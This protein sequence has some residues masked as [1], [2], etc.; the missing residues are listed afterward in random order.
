M[1]SMNTYEQNTDKNL[2]FYY[3]LSAINTAIHL[4]GEDGPSHPYIAP[5]LYHF[6][7]FG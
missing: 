7:I 3:V 1:R 2:E 4:S 5:L 6:V